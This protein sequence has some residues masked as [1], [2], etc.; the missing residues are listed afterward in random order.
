M[1][2]DKDAAG[3]CCWVT[4][5]KTTNSKRC[6]VSSHILIQAKIG[7]DC[8][9]VGHILKFLTYILMKLTRKD[10]KINVA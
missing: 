3:R 10:M 6:S 8:Y 2:V 9:M 1:L 4:L 7:V 5:E